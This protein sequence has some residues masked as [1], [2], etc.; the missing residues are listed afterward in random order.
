MEIEKNSLSILIGYLILTVSQMIVQKFYWGNVILYPVL[1]IVG[2]I[3]ALIIWKFNQKYSY[4]NKIDTKTTNFKKIFLWGITGTILV[5]IGQFI[6]LNISHLLFHQS[7]MSQNTNALITIFHQS[8]IYFLDIVF[9]TP[10]VEE[11]IFRK[12]LFGNLI[13]YFN[14]WIA[15]II[16][17]FLFGTAHH[18]GHFLTY[19][20]MGCLFE[21]I[22]YVSHDIRASIIAHAGLNLTILIVT[23]I[24]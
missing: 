21:F 19:F 22:Y 13:D 3:G 2:L 16:S 8:P 11:L 20:V 9:A 24:H 1:T 23:G 15:A 14:P 12:V 4:L 17:S 10:I 18:D 6:T 7:M 5:V